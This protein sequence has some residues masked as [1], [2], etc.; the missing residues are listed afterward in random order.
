MAGGLLQNGQQY[1]DPWCVQGT[2]FIPVIP[3]HSANLAGTASLSAQWWIG[4]GVSF[5]GGNRDNDNSWFEFSGIKQSV[6]AAGA[7]VNATVYDRKL[8]NQYGGYVQGQYWFTNQWFVNATWGMIR[9]FGI[10]TGTSA[11]LAGQAGNPAGYKYA[12]NNDQQKLNNEFDL[13]LWY[14]PIEAFKFGL[15]YSYDRSIFLQKINN[16]QSATGVGPLVPAQ[17]QGQPAAGAKDVGE[18]HRVQFVAFM[19]F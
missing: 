14:R 8:M 11:L 2:L 5:V 6:N 19:F 16:P 13:T 18:A 9:N 7:V 12:S 4:Q 3:T 10:D 1:L 15:Q 17:V